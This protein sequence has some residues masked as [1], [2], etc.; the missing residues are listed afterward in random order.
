MEMVVALGVFFIAI[1]SV[2][3]SIV[4][5]FPEWVGITGEKAKKVIESHSEEKKSE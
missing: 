2:F 1:T 5:F 4:F 3:V